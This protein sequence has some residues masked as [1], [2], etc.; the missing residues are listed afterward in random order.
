MANEK[1]IWDR[2]YAS[3]QNPYGVA[4]VMGNFQAESAMR[5][6]NLQDS[7][8]TLFGVNDEQYTAAVDDGSYQ[9]FVHDSAGYGLYQATFWSIKQHLLNYARTTG[10]SVGDW[11]MQVDQF[12]DLLKSEYDGVWQTLLTATSVRQASDA[13]LLKFERPADQSERAQVYRASQGQRFFDEFVREPELPNTTLVGETM[14][15]SVDLPVLKRGDISN[16][17]MN[18]QALLIQHGYFCGGR[19]I[20]GRENPD[21]D[22]GPNTE[23]AVKS[24]QNLRKLEPDGKI[25]ARTWTVLLTE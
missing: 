24:F 14:T 25:C 23:K 11:A 16:T 19:V 17:V 4:G 20:A 18:A 13:V 9:N 22:F 1:A 15:V 21:G 8:Q 3:I 5:A 7:Y 12:V 10:K 6:N 2:L